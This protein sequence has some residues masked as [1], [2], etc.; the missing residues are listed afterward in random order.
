MEFKEIV[1]HAAVLPSTSKPVIR[2]KLAP[3][4]AGVYHGNV[5]LT[6]V[7]VGTQTTESKDDVIA[8]TKNQVDTKS[9]GNNVTFEALFKEGK[10]DAFYDQYR[11]FLKSKFEHTASVGDR[12]MLIGEDVKLPQR[13]RENLTQETPEQRRPPSSM[14]DETLSRPSLNNEQ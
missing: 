1:K 2:R 9:E 11:S 7:T 14:R 8:N 10:V 4:E 6:S 5:A 12:W 13:R 3:D